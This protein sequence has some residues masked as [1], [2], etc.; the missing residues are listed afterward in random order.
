LISALLTILIIFGAVAG[1]DLPGIIKKKQWKELAVYLGFL[2]LG[3][4]IMTLHEAFKVD[5]SEVTNALI[6]VFS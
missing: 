5:F 1:M 4:T 2:I 6:K 3:F